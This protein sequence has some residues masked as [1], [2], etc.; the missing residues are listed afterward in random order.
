MIDRRE[1]VQKL[2]GV[3]LDGGNPIQWV[4]LICDAA[5]ILEQDEVRFQNEEVEPV[6]RAIAIYYCPFCGTEVAG[7]YVNARYKNWDYH[8]DKFCS[9]C[10]AKIK[11]E[12]D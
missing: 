1:L 11:W 2:R 8:I 6:S 12:R 3:K 4:H 9:Q 5:D 7:R 10:G